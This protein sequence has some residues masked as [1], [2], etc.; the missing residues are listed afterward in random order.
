MT[1]NIE[2]TYEIG[3]IVYDLTNN[4]RGIV[5]GYFVDKKDVLYR[6]KMADGHTDTYYK[7]SLSNEKYLEF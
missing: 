4:M 7:H 6:V 1:I 3:E 2:V 5:I